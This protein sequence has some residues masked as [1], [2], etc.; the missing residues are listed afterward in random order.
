[1]YLP[2]N[3]PL[4]KNSPPFYSAFLSIPRQHWQKTFSSF[5]DSLL[6][7]L[8]TRI[9]W[10]YRECTTY[11]HCEFCAGILKA[12]SSPPSPPLR[13]YMATMKARFSTA[14]FLPSTPLTT[15]KLLFHTRSRPIYRK[16]NVSKAQNLHSKPTWVSFHHMCSKWFRSTD[17]FSL[18]WSTASFTAGITPLP[19]WLSGTD[20]S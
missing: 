15:D 8:H 5:P 2:R 13:T 17:G 11:F 20:L 9:T 7:C 19:M 3:H 10:L 4:L 14:S 16:T 12:S 18:M 1:M 6:T